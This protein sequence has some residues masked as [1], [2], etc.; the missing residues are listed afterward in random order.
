MVRH[1]IAKLLSLMVV[2]IAC[3]SQSSAYTVIVR[4]YSGEG[5]GNGYRWIWD[6][7]TDSPPLCMESSCNDCTVLAFGFAGTGGNGD[8]TPSTLAG[9]YI[10]TLHIDQLHYIHTVNTCSAPNSVDGQTSAASAVGF[11]FNNSF[12][13]EIK[14]CPHYPHLQG[15][16]VNMNGVT[17]D[18]NGNCQIYIPVQ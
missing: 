12:A 13:M 4:I 1:A 18:A 9:G 14:D 7:N 3:T 8:I 17:V 11:T 6:G 2:L 5:E 10:I 16:K 15:I